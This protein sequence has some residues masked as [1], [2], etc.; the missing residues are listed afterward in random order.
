M[1]LSLRF[2]SW[3][4]PAL[5]LAA[6]ALPAQINFDEPPKPLEKPPLT[7]EELAKQEA[8]ELLRQARTLYGV[9][10]LR[11]RNDQ[12]VEA[13]E[14]LEKAAKLDPDSPAPKRALAPL[15]LLLGRDEDMLAACK[16]VVERDPGDYE[17]WFLYGQQLKRTGRPKEAADAFRRAVAC[18]R[19]AAR[20]ERRL[21]MLRDLAG[22]LEMDGQTAEAEKAYR[23][24]IKLLAAERR[25]IQEVEQLEPGEIDGLAGGCWEKVG[26]LCID[27]KRFDA[28]GQAFREAQKAYRAVPRPGAGLQAA[29]LYWNLAEVYQAQNRWADALEA[30]DSFLEQQP[31]EVEPYERK[32]SLLRKLGRERDVV[33][34]LRKYAQREPYHI[35]LQLLLARELGKDR[36]PRFHR[37]AEGIYQKLAESYTNPNIYRGLFRLYQSED[38]AER[39]LALVD[40]TLTAAQPKDDNYDEARVTA[41]ERGRAMLSVLR[42]DASLVN[43]LLRVAVREIEVRQPRERASDTWR[44]LAV[45]AARTKQLDKAE[46]LFRQALVR[47]PPLREPEVYEGLLRVLWAEHKRDAVAAICRQALARKNENNRVLFHYHLALALADQ[48]KYDDALAQADEAIKL[49]SENGKLMM[50]CRKVAILRQAERYAAAVAE[51]EAMLKEYSQ[52]AQVREVRY[53]LSHVYSTMGEHAKSEGQLRLILEL[54]PND[55]TANNDLGYQMADRNRNL[56]EAEKLIRKAVELDRAQ[57]RDAAEDEP[58]NA[59][60]LDSLGWVLFRKGKLAEARDWLEKASALSGGAEDPTVWDHLGDVYYRMDESAR[61]RSAWEKALKLYDDDR[62]ARKEER[63]DEVKR[64]LKMMDSAS[65]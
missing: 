10:L 31:P 3:S 57:R 30:L 59:A 45:M 16:F 40:E 20:P 46:A 39:V 1:P 33:P 28:A 23:S 5:L 6:P 63:R 36:D 54:D 25:T 55:A 19:S 27:L 42:E 13:L 62:R 43:A 34:V 64:K 29:R 49:T 7:R 61:A 41:A 56:D 53:T 15:Y 17:T 8:N 22:L 58:D 47:V 44:L 24:V 65:P 21:V 26:K 2:F 60:F 35:G 51:C 52:A 11:Q 48:E 37:E 12:L 32:L 4:V 38:R 14:T 9:G 18:E 50:R